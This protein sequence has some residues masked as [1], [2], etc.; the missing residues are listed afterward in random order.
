MESPDNRVYNIEENQNTF[1]DRLESKRSMNE[2]Q[3]T[4]FI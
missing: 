4:R 1:E 3:N 2:E